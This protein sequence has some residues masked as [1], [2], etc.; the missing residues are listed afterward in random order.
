MGMARRVQTLVRQKGGARGFAAAAWR[1]AANEGWG[2]VRR[3]TAWLYAPHRTATAR[4]DPETPPDRNDYQEWVRRYDQPTPE[5]R[6]RLRAQAAA[7]PVRPL[8]SIV[9]PTYNSQPGWLREAIASVRAQVYEH[10]ELCIADDASTRPEV[11]EILQ[12]EAAADPRIKL[13]LLERNG[14]ISVASNAALEIA[15]GEWIALLDH[16]DLLAEG[17]LF[18][19]ADAIARNPRARLIYSDEDKVSAEGQR[20]TPYFKC[21]WNLDLFYTHNLVTHLGVYHADLVRQVGGFTVG[22][23]GAQDYDLALRCVEHIA[24]DQVHHIPRILYH[25]RM[26]GESTAQSPAAKPYAAAAGLRALQQHLQRRGVDATVSQ[27]PSGLRVQ[28]AL[29]AQPPLVS[30]VIPTRNGVRLLR[31][32]VE[33]IL[34]KTAYAHY[35]IIVVDNGSDDPATLKYLEKLRSQAKVRVLRDDRPFNYSA[36]NNAAV[37]LAGG[38]LVGLLNNDLEVISPDWLSEMVALAVQPDVGVVGAR[39]LYPNGTLQ[40]AGVV[41][42]VGGIAGHAHKN[43]PRKAYG[44]FGRACSLQSFSAVTAA[45]LVVRKAI[46]QQVGGLDEEQLA[47]AFNDVDFCLRVRAAGL[48]N[49]WTPFAELYHHESATRGLD[50]TPQKQARFAHEVQ[51]MNERWGEQLRNDPA[52]SPNLTL[53]FEDFSF[54]WP[55]RLPPA[56]TT[57]VAAASEPPAQM[58]PQNG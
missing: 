51:T 19:V 55:P 41:L 46:Y 21:D 16:D 56:L 17:T 36:L 26:H 14:H 2:G 54:A 10:W 1:I 12:R 3:R 30:L 11:R 20:V 31:R 25:W 23:E 52:Y 35:E 45:C 44:Y 43:L 33:S 4:L 7:L 50:D 42:G 39:L 53:S 57:S 47:V 24:P 40:H 37:Q 32:C 22:L 18:W 58:A 6:A 13:R 48:R 9:M 8:I 5:S 29:P 27:L 34:R 15:S 38:E 49:V 28:Y